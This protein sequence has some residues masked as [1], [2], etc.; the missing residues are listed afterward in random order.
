MTTGPRISTSPSSSSLISQSGAGGPTV[1]ILILS[2]G[3]QVP[4]PQ[5]S[6]MPHSSAS[7]TPSA[8]KNSIT[9]G[10]VGRGADVAGLHQVEAEHARALGEH[11]LVGLLPLL[12][13]LGGNL[14]AGLDRA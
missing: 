13:E 6:D 7:G 12:L 5:V 8:W 14:L 9:S 3:L 4:A 11:L 1:P 2:G 10:G